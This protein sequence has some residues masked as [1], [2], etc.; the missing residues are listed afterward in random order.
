VC[1][2]FGIRAFFLGEASMADGTQMNQM[3]ETLA[4]LKKT[5]DRNEEIRKQCDAETNKKFETITADFKNIQ[6]NFQ[7][8]FKIIQNQLK[9]L[10][11][12]VPLTAGKEKEF[13]LKQHLRKIK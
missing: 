13:S 4:A 9:Q 11:P 2:K 12:A 10:I 7:N 3:A 6:C 8:E 5:V 1:N